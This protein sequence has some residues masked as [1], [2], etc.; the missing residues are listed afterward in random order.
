MVLDNFDEIFMDDEESMKMKG[1]IATMPFYVD[2]GG[3]IMT[4]DMS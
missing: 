1:G 3:R 2:C 4:Y